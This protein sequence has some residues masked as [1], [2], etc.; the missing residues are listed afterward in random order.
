[1]IKSP[2]IKPLQWFFTYVIVI[3]IFSMHVFIPYANATERVHIFY[4]LWYG[5]P[6]INGAY[7]HW[8]HEV[9]PHWDERT[10]ARFLTIGSRFKPPE[11]LHSP[12]Y[13]YRGPYSSTNRTLIKE[14]FDEIYK[15]GASVIV[16]SWSGI[17]SNPLATDTQGVNTD[18]A[19]ELLL[20]MAEEYITHDIKIC[21]HLEPYE[22]R[23]AEAVNDDIRYIID[24]YGKY[25]SLFRSSDGRPFL[26]VYDSY[27]I[28]P[29]E[30]ARILKPDGDMTI[31]G[32]KYDSVV[33]GLW[34]HHEHGQ[35]LVNGGFDGIY[36]YFATDGFS[37][38]TSSSNWNYMC[39]FCAQN[40]LL[41]ILSVAPGY[42][43]S[44]IRPWNV[45]SVRDR[46]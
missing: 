14:H 26:Y 41:C 1:M 10:N 35:D 30:W 12:F 43:D 5:N 17:A 8:N 20:Q 22:G 11:R 2:H 3:L 45:F 7:T 29:Q 4:Y 40:N 34:L 18:K 23:T 38:G 15:T 44:L 25:R 37:F 21:F 42:D 24:R 32:T 31:R 46:R 9:L 33:I 16:A 19:V 28:A 27:H 36:T 6:K 39:T 13:P